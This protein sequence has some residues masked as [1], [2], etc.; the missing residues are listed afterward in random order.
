MENVLFC[1]ISSS[2]LTVSS[3]SVSQTASAKTIHAIAL[4]SREWREAHA[5]KL[6]CVFCVVTKVSARLCY[7]KSASFPLLLLLLL[8]ILNLSG[9]YFLYKCD[10]AKYL[11]TSVGIKPFNNMI[12]IKWRIVVVYRFNKC[13]GYEVES[14]QHDWWKLARCV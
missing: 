2:I 14:I 7:V 10:S 9:V 12:C 3:Y 5:W 6:T 8:C 11:Y 13:M 1:D 4:Y